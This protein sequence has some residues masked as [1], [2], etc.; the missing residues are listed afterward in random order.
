MPKSCINEEL[1][2]LGSDW[3]VEADACLDKIVEVG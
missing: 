2:E 1:I 3:S